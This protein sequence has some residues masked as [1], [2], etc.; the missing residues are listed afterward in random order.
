MSR[1]ALIPNMPRASAP[2]AAILRAS[3]L[4][5]AA[6]AALLAGGCAG[7]GLELDSLA[8]AEPDSSAKIETSA[9][10]PASTGSKAETIPA[11]PAGDAPEAVSHPA[12]AKSRQLRANGDL[13]GAAA[14]LDQDSSGD[15]AVIK[16]RGLLALERG[17]IAEAKTLLGKADKKSTA[18]DW[19]I[20]SALGSALAASGDQPA[21]QKA[22]AE[23]LVLAPDHPSI[24]NNL[25]LSYALDGRHAEAEKMLRRAATSRSAN[26]RAKQNLA[27]LLG[28]SGQIEEARAVSEAAL[29]KD[30]S[31]ANMS[32]LE[33]LR[34]GVQVSRA[35]PPRSDEDGTPAS[36]ML[37]ALDPNR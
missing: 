24:L 5:S 25:A 16:E 37:D 15:I 8:S 33:G 7:S 9:L 30:V 27:L 23:A 21:A 14:A 29:P 36:A 11:S 22:F 19:R 20:K 12:I 6:V 18:P 17:R 35:A 28:L 32:Y 26:G 4:I 34:T 1:I 13:E 3:P 2:T 31:R 10:P